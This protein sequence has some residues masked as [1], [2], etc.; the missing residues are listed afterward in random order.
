MKL[1]IYKD[2]NEAIN[3]L[4]ETVGQI[5]YNTCYLQDQIDSKKVSLEL[6]LEQFKATVNKIFINEDRIRDLKFQRDLY[7]CKFRL[8]RLRSEYIG[9][10][11]IAL[12]LIAMV[13]ILTRRVAFIGETF[14][15]TIWTSGAIIGF[16][17]CTAFIVFVLAW[18]FAKR[19][20]QL[21]IEKDE[22]VFRLSPEEYKKK[23]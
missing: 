10:R 4:P 14:W 5:F 13:I 9:K 16:C 8:G 17:V 3:D 1:K 7:D 20:E 12:F 6:D 18:L 11:V 15:Q 23:H 2:L 19:P 22:D 21:D